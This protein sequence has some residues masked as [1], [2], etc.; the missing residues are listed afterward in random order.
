MMQA[1]TRQST[2][3]T[4]ALAYAPIPQAD[5]DRKREMA[6]AWKAY[7][8]KLQPPLKVS[9]GQTNDNVLSNRCAP[10][11][12]KGVSFLFGQTLKIECTNE[13]SEPDTEKQTC[14]DGVWGDDDTRMTLLSQLAINGGVCGEVFVKLIPA[15]GSMKYPRIVLLDPMLVRIVTD[16]EDCTLTIAYIIEY[17]TAG[18]VQ[19]RQVIARVDPLNDAGYAGKDDIE[20]T[21]TITNYERRGQ[22]GSWY[23][24]GEVEYW[25]YPFAPIFCT[26]NLPNPNEPWGMPDL[27]SDIIE[28]NKVLN[29]IQSNTARILKFHAH[30]KT[31]GRGFGASQITVGVDDVLIIQSPDGMLQNLEMTS[32]L[33]SSLQFASTIRSDMDEQSRVPAVALGRSVD[34]PKGNLSG[35][36]L[37]LLFQP[38]IEKTIQKRR[39]YGCMIRDVSRAALVLVGMLSI[40]EYADYPIDLHW[41]NLLPV[42]DMAAAQT[43]LLLQQIGVSNTTVMNQLGYDA[44]DELDKSAAEDKKK[45]Q[46]Y[47]E[48]TQPLPGNAQDGQVVVQRPM[49]GAHQE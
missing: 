28:M 8:G 49:D 17:P 32:D 39:L 22:A 7:R 33:Q 6:D 48:P 18:D 24:V 29:F 43:A 46:M 35:V 40:E 20:D 25:P 2:N 36:A 15:Q 9:P 47:G 44:D 31:W 11:V 42:D 26:Q 23:Q 5:M 37:Q 10:I 27:S 19:K 38:L 4:Q 30:P 45:Q 41:E 13:T 16:P 1:P 21:W 14:I 12:D 34:L 3:A